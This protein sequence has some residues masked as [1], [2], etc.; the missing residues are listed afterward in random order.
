MARCTQTGFSAW[1][2]VWFLGDLVW[3]A[4]EE[5]IPR[6]GQSEVWMLD[7]GQGSEGYA[8]T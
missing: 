3:H 4:E 7:E 6:V 1:N 5:V 8:Q 2:V